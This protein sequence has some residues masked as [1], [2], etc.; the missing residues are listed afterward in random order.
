MSAHSSTS[1][2]VLMA[3]SS[4]AAASSE[5]VPADA[6]DSELESLAATRLSIV[7]KTAGFTIPT[8]KLAIISNLKDEITMA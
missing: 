5:S 4:V 7:N 1:P 3:L 2:M 6:T 8:E